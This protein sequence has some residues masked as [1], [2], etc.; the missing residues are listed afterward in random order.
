[1]TA[2][3]K[4]TEDLPALAVS[5]C[6][7]ESFSVGC[8]RKPECGTSTNCNLARKGQYARQAYSLAVII[9]SAC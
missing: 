5:L 8:G 7:H 6:S 9:F 1:M 2:L 3:S 4:G